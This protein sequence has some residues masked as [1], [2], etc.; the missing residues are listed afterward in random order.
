MLV[1]ALQVLGQVK[2]PGVALVLREANVKHSDLVASS[3]AFVHSLYSQKNST[4]LNATTFEVYHRFENPP[5]LKSCPATDVDIVC[6][7]KRTHLQMKPGK[8]AVKAVYPKSPA[9]DRAWPWNGKWCPSC[10]RNLLHQKS[11]W[12]WLAT[13]IEQRVLPATG[14]VN[15]LSLD[16]CVP[17]TVC[18]SGDNCWNALSQWSRAEDGVMKI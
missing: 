18:E 16:W 3:L 11:W 12:T 13:V 17:D 2:M 1:S 5:S 4:S 7:L 15:V 9:M 10:R 8:S 6:H 14:R